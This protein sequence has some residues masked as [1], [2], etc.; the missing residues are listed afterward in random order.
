MAESAAGRTRI[1]GDRRSDRRYSLELEA[2]WSVA[3]RAGVESGEGRTVN[4]S[5]GGILLETGCAL[6]VGG[7]VE[8]WIAWPALLQTVAPRQLRV[9][10]LVV[11]SEHGRTAIRIVRVKFRAAG[12]AACATAPAWHRCHAVGF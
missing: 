3:S 9:Q 5:S 6:P 4:L 8:L 12:K 11:R 2:R 1:G 10:G 7:R